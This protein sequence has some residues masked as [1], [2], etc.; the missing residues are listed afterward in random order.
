MGNAETLLF[1]ERTGRQELVEEGKIRYVGV[2]ELGIANL[3]KAHAVHPITAYQMEWSLF[4]R[5][6]E[7]ELVPTCRE[8]GIGVPISH[9]VP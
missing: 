4:A 2:S 3:R 8:L 9:P 5:D 6:V 7:A 1:S